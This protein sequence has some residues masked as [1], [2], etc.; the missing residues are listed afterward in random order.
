LNPLAETMQ[1]LSPGIVDIKEGISKAHQDYG[2]TER[3]ELKF[4]GVVFPTL[5]TRLHLTVAVQPYYA[6]VGGIQYPDI[7]CPIDGYV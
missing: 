5:E 7:A 4:Q 3:V 1:Q 2:F 6:R